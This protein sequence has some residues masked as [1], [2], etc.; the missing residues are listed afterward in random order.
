MFKIHLVGARTNG[1]DV[2]SIH[3]EVPAVP[4]CGDHV[5]YDPIDGLSGYVRSVSYWWDEKNELTIE[6]QL[7]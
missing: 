6:V 2:P 4:A 1:G 7:K 3:V 5:S